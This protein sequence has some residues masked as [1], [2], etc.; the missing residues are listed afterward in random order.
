MPPPPGPPGGPTRD[1]AHE[2]TRRCVRHAHG[3][4][5]HSAACN[6]AKAIIISHISATLAPEKRLTERGQQIAALAKGINF[7]DPEGW[8]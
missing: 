4:R 3:E 5:H 8:Q 2:I 6:E 1:A 7:D